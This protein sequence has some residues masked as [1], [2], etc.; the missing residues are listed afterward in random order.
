M[1][2]TT[3]LAAA[4]ESLRAACASSEAE[5]AALPVDQWV[6][7]W[8]DCALKISRE[9]QKVGLCG[10]EIY[11]GPR[12]QMELDAARFEQQVNKGNKDSDTPDP[13]WPMSVGRALELVREKNAQ[14][15]ASLPQA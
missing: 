13:V 4:I 9:D 6:I 12:W 3:S 8:H 1:T 14:L 11:V 7:V 15:L 2:K 10:D 5:L